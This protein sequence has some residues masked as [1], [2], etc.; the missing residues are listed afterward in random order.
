MALKQYTDSSSLWHD[1]G[2][3]LYCRSQMASGPSTQQLIAKAVNALQ[4]A[5]SLQPTNH[6]HWTALGVVAA[7]KG[8]KVKQVKGWRLTS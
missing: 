3:N 7:S 1:L 2:I 6:K 4:K 8:M 5:V